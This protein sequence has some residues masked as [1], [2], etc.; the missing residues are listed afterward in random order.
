MDAIR[1][2]RSIRRFIEKEIPREAVEQL[3]ESLIWAPSAG[4]LQARKFYFVFK[5]LVKKE[6][7]RACF[8]QSFV[9]QAPLLVIAC[10]D[11]D[12]IS[13]YGKRGRELYA[14]LD[15]A[16]SIQNLLLAAHSLGLGTCWVAA[17]D[18]ENVRAILNAPSHLKPVSII[19]VGFPAE[20]PSPPKRRSTNEV[21]EEIL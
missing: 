20:K 6:I 4:N 3:K 5:P 18:E 11:F 1:N 2:R 9:A 16:A 10:V 12:K 19:P 15:V 17:F 8:N 7:A 21:C 13:P 14:V